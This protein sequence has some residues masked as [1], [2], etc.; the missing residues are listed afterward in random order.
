MAATHLK[1]VEPLD[2]DRDIAEVAGGIAAKEKALIVNRKSSMGTTNGHA[3]ADVLPPDS[4]RYFDDLG[5]AERFLDYVGDDLLYVV[6][7]GSWLIWDKT[8]W[9]WDATNMVFDMV[10]QFARGLYS[11]E[12]L[13]A[14]GKT[15][16][17]HA[18]RTNNNA[19]LNAIMSIAKQKSSASIA[20]FDRE[21]Y[22]LNCV[23]GTLDLKTGAL[24][25]HDREDRITRRVNAEYDADARSAVFD[26][27]IET[28]QPD[29]TVRAFLQRVMGYA[30][31]GTVRE[32]A[33]FILYGTGNNGKSIFTNLFNNLLGEYAATTTA[34]TIMQTAASSGRIPNDIAKL[35]GKRLVIVP[36]TNENER[37]NASVIKALSAGDKVSARHLFAE[38]F[39]FYF[40]A[41]ILIATNHKP[42]ITDHS[43]GFWDRCKLIPF[44]QDIPASEVIKSDDLMRDLMADAPAVLAWAVQGARDYFESDGLDVPPVIQAEIDAYKF[45]QDSIAQFVAE[46]CQTIE[47]AR[48]LRPDIYYNEYDF[49]TG[50]GDLFIAYRKF[51]NDNGFNW[52]FSKPRLTKN[53]KER[54]YRQANSGGRYWEGIR[55][56]DNG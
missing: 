13:A 20:D 38:W 21:P 14:G 25:P 10:T 35:K 23:N 30:L 24:R 43:K 52:A 39:D 2:V 17:A 56:V 47:Q 41:K 15:A 22:L 31:L 50:N 51:C 27:F 44:S 1:L 42:T 9:T 19:G 32:R 4:T 6:E 34:E 53:M 16:I 3:P 54:G 29:A 37:L 55:L 45:E 49:R 26:R 48:K 18:V 8:H 7:K 33:F 28:I 12:N 46:C 11:A 5:N 36:E 40:T